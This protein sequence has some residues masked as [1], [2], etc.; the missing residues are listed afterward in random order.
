M[1]FPM[2]PFRAATGVVDRLQGLPL[3]DD[4]TLFAIALCKKPNLDG[5]GYDSFDVVSA[6]PVAIHFQLDRQ[7]LRNKSRVRIPLIEGSWRDLYIQI[8]DQ[9]GEPFG[10]GVVAMG[11]LAKDWIEASSDVITI[12]SRRRD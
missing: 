1:D 10:K 4:I 5:V 12:S 9:D 8:H 3:P 11:G 7:E 2:T 6:D